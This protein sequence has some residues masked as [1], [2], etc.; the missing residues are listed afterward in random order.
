MHRAFSVAPV[1]SVHLPPNCR[2]ITRPSIGVARRRRPVPTVRVRPDATAEVLH[3]PCVV[4]SRRSTTCVH[5]RARCRGGTRVLLRGELERSVA[6]RDEHVQRLVACRLGDLDVDVDG[7]RPGAGAGGVGPRREAGGVGRL[8]DAQSEAPRRVRHDAGAH[9]LGQCESLG[10]TASARRPWP[11][12]GGVLHDPHVGQPGVVDVGV[13]ERHDDLVGDRC[14]SSPTA[15]CGRDGRCRLARS[16]GCRDQPRAAG[17]RRPRASHR[18][19]GSVISR[20]TL[21][22][23]FP[24]AFRTLRD[25]GW[26]TG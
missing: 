21:P 12:A 11:G 5:R 7:A 6:P 2:P 19:T 8:V 13:H 17:V 26:G 24:M 25:E 18:S 10:R 15:S 22:V 9:L 16:I 1:P 3:A 4:R 14:T 23:T 20:S